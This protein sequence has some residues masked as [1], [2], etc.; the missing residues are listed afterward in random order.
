MAPCYPQSQEAFN[1]NAKWFA[2]EYRRIWPVYQA[3]GV[4]AAKHDDGLGRPCECRL[5]LVYREAVKDA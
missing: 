2:D 5:C 3:V 1:K 4:R